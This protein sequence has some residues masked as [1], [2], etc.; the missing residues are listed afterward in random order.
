MKNFLQQNWYKIIFYNLPLIAILLMIWSYNLENNGDSFNTTVELMNAALYPLLVI[1][2]FLYFF[3]SVRLSIVQ[4]AKERF[5]I[6]WINFLVIF[7]LGIAAICKLTSA[8]LGNATGFKMEIWLWALA[9]AILLVAGQICL[10]LFY[11]IR[12]IVRKIRNK[13]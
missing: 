3:L 7:A 4:T 5:K 6:I 8:L 13:K 1:Q 9:F 10:Y 2:L 11:L 12:I